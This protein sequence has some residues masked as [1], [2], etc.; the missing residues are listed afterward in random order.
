MPLLKAE[1]APA[2]ADERRNGA[3]TARRG[4]QAA[5][6]GHTHQPAFNA[7]CAALAASWA[8]K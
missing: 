3:A 8:G 7:A 5:D 4:A 6:G 1:Q 2:A